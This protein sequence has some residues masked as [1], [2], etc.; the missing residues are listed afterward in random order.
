MPLGEGNVIIHIKAQSYTL[1]YETVQEILKALPEHAYKVVSE[2]Y[3]WKYKDG[4]D[5]SGFLDGT[6]NPSV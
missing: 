4:R 3:G 6:M 1:A 2:R 5:L